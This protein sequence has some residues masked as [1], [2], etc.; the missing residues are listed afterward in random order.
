MIQR[1]VNAIEQVRLPGINVISDCS[2]FEPENK[3]CDV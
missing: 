1:A 2:G 3:G